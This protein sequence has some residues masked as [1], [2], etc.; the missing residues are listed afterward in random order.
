MIAAVHAEIVD[1]IRRKGETFAVINAADRLAY[2][3]EAASGAIDTG[4]IYRKIS[5]QRIFSVWP[6]TLFSFTNHIVTMIFPNED[7]SK[8]IVLRDFQKVSL[9]KANF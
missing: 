8:I 2:L 7:F 5:L 6:K 9:G 4:R 3:L 1:C